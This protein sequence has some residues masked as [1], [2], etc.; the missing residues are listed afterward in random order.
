MF[1]KGKVLQNLSPVDFQDALQK[2]E[3]ID[4]IFVAA[5]HPVRAHVW[6]LRAALTIE[7]VRRLP[8][9]VAAEVTA[10]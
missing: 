2:I 9:R 6:A 4:D 1:W 5:P 3:E 8:Q 7:Q 10:K